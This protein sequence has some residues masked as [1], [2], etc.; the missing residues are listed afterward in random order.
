MHNLLF[1]PTLF[2]SSSFSLFYVLELNTKWCLSPNWSNKRRTEQ[3]EHRHD[4]LRVRLHLLSYCVQQFLGNSNENEEIKQPSNLVIGVLHRQQQIEGPFRL[5]VRIVTDYFGNAISCKYRVSMQWMDVLR[6]ADLQIR[7]RTRGVGCRFW[8]YGCEIWRKDAGRVGC[9]YHQVLIKLQVWPVEMRQVKACL[10][11]CEALASSDSR[12]LICLLMSTVF[13][14][15]W[16]FIVT[17]L[18]QEFTKSNQTNSEQKW[19]QKQSKIK[20]HEKCSA[21]KFI[22]VEQ[23]SAEFC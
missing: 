9:G 5:G 11:S 15:L 7:T 16:L 1:F 21:A 3:D 13:A 23:R 12:Y 10:A 4:L 18:N 17:N 22:S 19:K 8:G 20:W 6:V 2:S 14:D